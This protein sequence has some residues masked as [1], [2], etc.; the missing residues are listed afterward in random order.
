MGAVQSSSLESPNLARVGNLRPS[1]GWRHRSLYF[2]LALFNVV[3]VVLS[4]ALSHRLEAT[5]FAS[6]DVNERWADHEQALTGLDLAADVVNA[7]GNDVFESHDVDRE[8]ARLHEA[9]LAYHAVSAAVRRNVTGLDNHH[10]AAKAHTFLD[11]IDSEVDHMIEVARGVFELVSRGDLKGAAATMAQMDRHLTLA[12]AEIVRMKACAGDAQKAYFADQEQGMR[13]LRR[14]EMLVATLVVVMVGATVAYGV[15]FSRRMQAIFDEMQQAKQAAEDANRSKSEF[16]AN[17]SHEIRTPMNGI[18]GLTEVVLQ[19]SLAPEQRQHLDLVLMSADALM[20]E[21]NEILDFSK[22]E[23]G[24]MQLDSEDFDLR[25]VVGNAAKL[26]GLRARQKDLEL[27]CRVDRKVPDYVVGDS[28]RIGQIL[29][30]LIGNAVKFTSRGEIVVD[31]NVRQMSPESVVIE[32]TVRDT[33]IGIATDKLDNIFEAFTQADGSTT[34]RFGGT[35][36]GLTI[37]KRIVELMGGRI[38]VDSEPGKGSTFGFHIVC[39]RSMRTRVDR[40]D[41]LLVSLEGLRVLVVDDNATNRLILREM[42]DSW[43]MNPTAVEDGPRAIAELNRACGIRRPYDL[44]LLDAHMHDMDG[45]AVAQQV[46]QHQELSGTRIMMLTSIDRCDASTLCAQLGLD[47][48]LTKPIKQSELLDAIVAIQLAV[49]PFEAYNDRHATAKQSCRR[50]ERPLEILVAEDNF[51]NQQVV[52]HI[53]ERE[54]HAV[55][56]AN[57][58]REAVEA[59]AVHRYDVVLMDVQMPVLDGYEATV[60]I[61]NREESRG[62]RLPIIALTAHAMRG[63][64]ERCLG[65]GMDAYVTKPIQVAALLSTIAEVLDGQESCPQSYM[66][67]DSAELAAAPAAPFDRDGLLARTCGDRDSLAA[68]TDIFRGE[69]PR[70]LAGIRAAIA[71]RDGQTLKNAAHSCKGTAANLGGVGAATIAKR[72]EDLAEDRDFDAAS[73]AATLL[74]ASLDSLV[75]QLEALLAEEP[76]A[77]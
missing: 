67:S 33:G 68:L 19:T 15:A 27:I 75:A 62:G 58:G 22:I 36:L 26:L 23:A 24:K 25:E 37:C 47:S 21:L 69:Q 77:S 34:R 40:N 11:A 43:L 57:N 9:A 71:A 29:A 64:N 70:Q 39:A 32:F 18:I 56:F 50:L 65:A 41:A 59:V 42:L 76:V 44:V 30:N 1:R 55:T 20:N 63:D 53:L 12:T 13:Q 17:M 4:L 7:P 60:E 8:R 66:S 16:L 28:V 49:P 3:T 51:V 35:G 5:Y 72:I 73:Q 46:R 52:R 6:V 61:R 2:L 14:L 45:F 38:W 74:A 48:Y 31:V 54:G 10:Y